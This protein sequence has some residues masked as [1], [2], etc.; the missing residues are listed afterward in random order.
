MYD[1]K[2]HTPAFFIVKYSLNLISTSYTM[3]KC[4]KIGQ[5]YVLDN[6]IMEIIWKI[7]DFKKFISKNVKKTLTF[8]AGSGILFYVAVDQLFC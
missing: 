3:K 5:M 4:H 7:G 1:C 8:V 6:R 2:S